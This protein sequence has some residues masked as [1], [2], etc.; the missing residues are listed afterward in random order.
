MPLRLWS[1]EYTMD[2]KAKKVVTSD[3]LMKDHPELNL[4]AKAIMVTGNAKTAVFINQDNDQAIRIYGINA[5]PY[6]EIDVMSFRIEQANTKLTTIHLFYEPM[7]GVISGKP[8]ERGE[9][10]KT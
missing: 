2:A 8:T 10:K 7:K 1:K 5:H 3:E 4:P 6:V 9:F